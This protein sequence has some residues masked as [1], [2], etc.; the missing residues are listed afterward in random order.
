M[1]AVFTINRKEY[2]VRGDAH[3]GLWDIRF[4]QGYDDNN[5]DILGTGDSLE[6]FATVVEI[7]DKFLAKANYPS[8]HFFAVHKEAS[9]VRLYDRLTKRILQ[10]YSG[11]YSY[12]NGGDHKESRNAFRASDEN[13]KRYYFINGAD[14][15]KKNDLGEPI[16]TN[17]DFIGT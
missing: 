8:F 14:R 2:T 3:D 1:Q 17:S 4:E 13:R 6:V 9:R 10:K 5:M 15:K 11:K 12:S 16:W 7:L